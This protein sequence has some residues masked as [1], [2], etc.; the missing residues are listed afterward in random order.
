M[1]VFFG[2]VAVNGSYFVQL[3]RLDVLPAAISVLIGLLTS[4]I[5]I[6]NNVRDIDTDRRAGK[7][8]FAVRAGRARARLAFEASIGA[9]YLL[10][11]VALLAGDGSAWGLLALLSAPLAL[12]PLKALRNREDGASLNLALAATGQLLA[13]YSIL[14][15]AGLLI[16]N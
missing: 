3:E 7:R 1:F 5:L 16:G 13:A 12:A 14:L 4:A 8:T 15:A 11:P 10:L 6:V 2:L 9:A